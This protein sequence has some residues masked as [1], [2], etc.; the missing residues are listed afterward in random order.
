LNLK[1]QAA[2]RQLSDESGKDGPQLVGP[3]APR[4]LAAFESKG[5]APL[6]VKAAVIPLLAALSEYTELGDDVL[7]EMARQKTYGRLHVADRWVAIALL[8]GTRD[9]LPIHLR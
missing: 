9:I 8:L 3:R 6:K 7:V 5:G 4:K 2:V 1:R